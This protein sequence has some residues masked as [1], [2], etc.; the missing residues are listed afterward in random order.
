MTLD[1][2]EDWVEEPGLA[3]LYDAKSARVL[4]KPEGEEPWRPAWL[5][6]MTWTDEDGPRSIMGDDVTQL[7]ENLAFHHFASTKSKDYAC[8]FIELIHAQQFADE[9]N[10]RLGKAAEMMR[11]YIQEDEG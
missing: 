5:I 7:A 9:A 1:E 8:A 4:Y 6:E 2:R 10:A 3:S 11:K